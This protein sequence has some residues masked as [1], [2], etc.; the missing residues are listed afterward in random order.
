MAMPM[1]TPVNEPGPRP[2]STA[3]RSPIERPASASAARAVVTSST[4]AWRRHI[5]SREASTVTEPSAATR[6]TAQASMSVDVSSARTVFSAL[7][8][9]LLS[10]MHGSLL[11]QA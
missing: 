6:P 10:L 11:S 3:S 2:T 7:L 4:L 8:A 1:R 5:W 9:G